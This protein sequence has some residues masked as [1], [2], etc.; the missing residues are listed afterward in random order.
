MIYHLSRVYITF[1]NESCYTT[2]GMP[3]MI[4]RIAF[5]ATFALAAT[6]ARIYAA[7]SCRK[8]HGSGTVVAWVPCHACNGNVMSSGMRCKTCVRSIKVGQVREKIPCP[9]CQKDATQNRNVG[10][11]DNRVF[12]AHGESRARRSHVRNQ[13]R[14]ALSAEQDSLSNPTNKPSAKSTK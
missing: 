14:A 1:P 11:G 10:F 13:I 7:T 4:F 2:H 9:V 3:N 5:L 12:A 8:C 6:S